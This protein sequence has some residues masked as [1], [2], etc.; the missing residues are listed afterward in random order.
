M[1]ASAAWLTAALLAAL[2]DIL[3]RRFN[4]STW[5]FHDIFVA[6]A[7]AWFTLALY[8][9]LAF[10]LSRRF[11]AGPNPRRRIALHVALAL[12]FWTLV[13]LT[14]QGLFAGVLSPH[15]RGDSTGVAD[16]IAHLARRGFEWTLNTLPAGAA[17]YIASVATEHAV[18]HFRDAR[19]RDVQVARLGEQLSGA[20][21]AALQAQLNPHFL[22]N[23]L[24][25]IAVRARDGDGQGTARMVEQL[26][27]VL[28]RTIGRHRANEVTL[29]DELDLVREY[30]DIE[31]ARFSDRLRV[32]FAVDDAVVSAAVPSFAVQHLVENAI[33]HGISKRP[34]A[35]TVT[36]AA[37]RADS[38]VE[39]VVADDGPGVH[40][41]IVVEGHGIDNTRQRLAALHGDHAS[42][43]LA[44]AAHGGAIATLRL[45]FREAALEASLA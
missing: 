38:D 15:A 27:E 26:S 37:R 13:G 25:T 45:P 29:E 4:G 39:I 7:G 20:R 35:G 16:L 11:P 3:V 28:R 5:A 33:R 12:A 17:I 18:R 34:D 2:N 32:T 8:T 40:D 41:V 19:D 44:N 21:F 43:V 9:P 1:F 30:L 6:G 31:H 36:I 23:T 24:N 22:F 10:F 14:F 42:L